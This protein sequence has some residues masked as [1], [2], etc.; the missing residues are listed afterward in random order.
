MVMA[1]VIHVRQKVSPCS[2][3]SLYQRLSINCASSMTFF[4]KFHVYENEI[5]V[6]DCV[7]L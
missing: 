6:T 3:L 4:Q 1:G 2:L 5:L 7:L